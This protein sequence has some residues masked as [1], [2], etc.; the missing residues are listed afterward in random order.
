M[1]TT[2][3][4]KVQG[5]KEG[6]Y[7]EETASE[8]ERRVRHEADEVHDQHLHSNITFC[9]TSTYIFWFLDLPGYAV[10]CLHGFYFLNYMVY[11][12]HS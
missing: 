4:R 10:Y 12:L 3:K 6:S 1:R 11:I 7:E 9:S 5:G 8:G 2:K